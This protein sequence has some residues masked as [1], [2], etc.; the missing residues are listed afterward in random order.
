MKLNKTFISYSLAD[1]TIARKLVDDLDRNGA[2]YWFDEL[3]VDPGDNFLVRISD[4]LVN[5]GTLC[6]V[7]TKNMY[8]NTGTA[9]EEWTNFLALATRDSNRRIVVLKFDESDPPPIIAA[10]SGIDMRDYDHG[11][12]DLLQF[13]DRLNVYTFLMSFDR[14][15]LGRFG[16]GTGGGQAI[17]A[18]DPQSPTEISIRFDLG[19]EDAFAGL[20]FESRSPVDIST[21]KNLIMQVRADPADSTLEV[22]LGRPEMTYLL[23][24]AEQTYKEFTIPI[25]YFSIVDPQR[26]TL[27]TLAMND[28]HFGGPRSG[29]RLVQDLSVR[30]LRFE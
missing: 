18:F 20:Y 16:G 28:S 30:N 26:V 15:R 24:G 2:A 23:G 11:I 22:K 17:V 12:K 1:A 6:L 27:L 3:D 7:L 19:P 4:G 9:R 13:L 10:R 5:C 14:P 8:D 25:S 21:K 29:S